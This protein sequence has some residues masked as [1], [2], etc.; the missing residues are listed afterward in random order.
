M[1]RE[2]TGIDRLIELVA[3]FVLGIATV[4]TAWCGYQATQWN[5]VQAS[6]MT[7]STD[8]RVEASRLFG[9]ATQKASYDSSMIAQYAQAVQAGNTKLA[10]FYRETLIREELLPVID[11]WE[12]MIK[13]GS[14]P[15]RLIDDT[16]YMNAQFGPYRAATAK[17]DA[18]TAQALRAGDIQHSYVITTIL[19]AVALFFSGVTSSFM[20]RPA[21]VLLVLAAIASLGVAAVNLADLPV[22]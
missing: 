17:A 1:K 7:A 12:T 19:L 20:W 3:V 5:G 15:T 6:A 2:F 18:A 21:R 22:A 8:A 13:A 4:G 11:R 14:I 9:L 10:T 16:S